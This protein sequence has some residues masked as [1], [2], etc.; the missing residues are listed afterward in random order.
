MFAAAPNRRKVQVSLSPS[1]NIK[2]LPL[3]IQHSKHRQQMLQVTEFERVY[4]SEQFWT[5]LC[6]ALPH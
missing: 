4:A 6:K 2:F 1:Q 5:H 3:Q